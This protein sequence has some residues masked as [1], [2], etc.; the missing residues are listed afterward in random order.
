M[1][2]E[3]VATEPKSG[4][5]DTDSRELLSRR[6]TLDV[7]DVPLRQAIKTLA[8]QANVVIG[9]R[10]EIVDAAGRNVTVHAT[11]QPLSAVLTQLLAGTRLYAVVTA[12]GVIALKLTVNDVESMG[13][14]VITGV[15]TDAATKRPV[16]GAIVTID[17]GRSVK[18]QSNGRFT[19][20]G[21]PAGGHTLIVRTL[22]YHVYSALVTVRDDATEMVTVALSASATTLTDVV[23]TATGQKQRMEVG[24]DVGTIKAD[25]IVATQQIRNV[26]DLLQ[27][28]LPG[29]VVSNTDGAVGSPSK[30]RLR[31][32]N[33]VS[34]NNDPIVIV[35]G[36]RVNAQTTQARLQTNVGSVALPQQVTGPASSYGAGPQAA[37]APS[38]LD[39]ID[40]NT[41]EKIEVLYGPSASSLYGTD[42]ANGVIVITTKRGHPGSLRTTLSADAGQ[43]FQAG[44]AP[45]MWWGWG[46][47]ASGFGGIEYETAACNLSMGGD[48]SIMAGKCVQDSVTQYNPQNDPNMRTLGTGTSNSIHGTVSGGSDQVQQFLTAS[49]ANNVGMARMSPAQKRVIQRLYNESPPSWMTRPNTQQE[50]DGSSRTTFTFGNQA[51]VSLSANGIYNNVLN[52]GNGLQSFFNQSN[53]ITVGASPGDTLT[54]LP[55]EGQRT[56]ISSL[57]KRGFMS[58][59]GEYRPWSWLRVNGTVG[60]DYTLRTDGAELRRQDCSTVLQGLENGQG[61]PSLHSVINNQVFVTT[62]NGGAAATYSPFS[63]LTLTTTVGEQYTHTDASALQVGN[64]DPYGCPLAFGTQLLTPA[65]VCLDQSAQQ[66]SVNESQDASAEAGVYLEETLNLFGNYYTFGVRRDVASGFGGQTIKQPPHYPKFNLSIPL[67]DKGFFPQQPYVS[68]LRVR[69]AYGQ[70]GNQASQTAVLNQ[71]RGLT[72]SN[73]SGSQTAIFPSNL[74]NSILRPEKSAEWEGGLDISFLENERISTKLTMSRKFTRDMIVSSRYPDSYGFAGGVASPTLYTNIGDVKSN[75][76]ELSV[77]ARVL[78][79][80]SFTWNLGIGLTKTS[81][82]LVHRSPTMD[83]DGYDVPS[84]H[85]G[86]PLYGFWATP[87]VAYSDANHDGIL[88]QDEVTLGPLQFAGAPY[89]TSTVN[90]TSNLSMLNGALQLSTTLV[91]VNGQTNPLCV[92]STC[93][94][95]PRAAVDRTASIAEQAAYLEAQFNQGYYMATASSLRLNEAALTY[96]VPAALSRRLVHTQSASVTLSGRNLGL[97]TDYAGKDP[98]VDTS[99]ALAEYS[100]NN[101]LGT[102]QPRSWILRVNLG[103]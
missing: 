94:V 88:A 67:S 74:G 61:C 28:R 100:Y 50:V 83:L 62:M 79:A 54:Y 39:D 23:T 33:S 1:A 75:D 99:G 17:S 58:G 70:S 53:N 73:G 64:A 55:S 32:V 38:R 21:I 15:V 52:G 27:G 101:G 43:S 91:Q 96:T 102:L 98:N 11:Q 14:G 20:N 29:V 51:D 59:D 49:V 47:F 19:M 71:Y 92:A 8:T 86:Y 65:P 37:L 31:G 57:A 45:E 60:G 77:D 25:S 35:D 78:D 12:P 36:I 89:P 93:G 87:V 10:R 9:Y 82:I 76:F 81:N 69:V 26:S 30:I 7:D 16:A 4:V 68:L 34:L 3:T 46:H 66:Y 95:Y 13:T 2:Q 63:W 90:Y 80:R 85:E 103:F 24:N 42:A 48:A 40:P 6:V 44:G 18:T 97:W 5:S 41:I 56:K 22:G 72:F 84:F